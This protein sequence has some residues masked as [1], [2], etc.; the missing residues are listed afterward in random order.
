MFRPVRPALSYLELA[1]G[2]KLYAAD[3]VGMDFSEARVVVLS[4]CESGRGDYER[5]NEMVGLPRALLRAGARSV[6]AALWPVED[7]EAL[8]A[9]M[10]TFYAGLR[11]GT[12]AEACRAAQVAA[13]RAGHPATLW[14][15][16]TLIGA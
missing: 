11:A 3:L 12:P 2:V 6:L 9:F 8:S 14:A 4:A 10:R 7:H 5:A 13:I 1:D 15:A 16:F